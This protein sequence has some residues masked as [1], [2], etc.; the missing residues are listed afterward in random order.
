MSEK[1]CLKRKF[2][3]SDVIRTAGRKI[4][5]FLGL[6]QKHRSDVREIGSLISDDQKKPS[7]VKK[8]DFFE[9]YRPKFAK[10]G[11]SVERDENNKICIFNEAIRIEGDADNTL[12][13]AYAI[14]C[15][16]EYNFEIDDKYV[17][18]DIGLNLGITSLHKARDEKC[19]KIYGYEP[20]TPTFKSA[21]NNMKLNPQLSEK[22]SVFNY[23]LGDRNKELEI[24]YNPEYPGK[25][26][27]VRNR[28]PDSG[29]IEKIEI[30]KASDVLAPLFEKHKEKIFLKIDC[31]GAEKEILPDLD[32]TGLLKKVTVIVME[33]H[34]EN[35]KRIVKLLKKNGFVY[36]CQHDVPDE[37]GMIRAYRGDLST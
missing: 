10:G 33:W 14:L 26:S 22:I 20:F 21:E 7:F 24:N 16:D 1:M 36:F 5:R 28:F 4:C 17:M 31:E 3:L 30:K 18:F 2:E 29:V 8:T 6:K 13:T 23:G 35:P 9:Q 37:I 32:E 34:F 25:M 11:Y 15:S 27:S 19:V 12:W